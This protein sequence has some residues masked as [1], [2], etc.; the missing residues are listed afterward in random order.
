MRG[1]RSDGGGDYPEAVYEAV[2]T[3]IDKRAAVKIVHPHL[4][5]DPRLPS[6]MAEAKAVNAIG[7]EGIVDVYGMGTMPDGRAYLLMA[8]GPLVVGVVLPMMMSDRVEVDDDHFVSTHGLPWDRTRHDI[9]FEQLSGISVEVTE[10][11][12]QK[13][14]KKTGYVLGRV[15]TSPPAVT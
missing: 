8:F 10:T 15:D 12:T 5:N 7:D 13:G 3:N 2:E 14:R 11:T 1:L 4:S 6:L 9:R